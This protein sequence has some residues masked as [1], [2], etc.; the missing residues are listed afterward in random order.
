MTGFYCI[1]RAELTRA[2]TDHLVGCNQIVDLGTEAAKA[3]FFH[4]MYN[5]AYT[6]H[7]LIS[8]MP[9]W[10]WSIEGRTVAAGTP[11]AVL[12]LQQWL[13]SASIAEVSGRKRVGKTRKSSLQRQQ[14]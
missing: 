3:A 8:A 10:Q 12:A 11:Q 2:L 13:Q 7:V 9:R 4:E 6:V 5:R 14:S 1:C